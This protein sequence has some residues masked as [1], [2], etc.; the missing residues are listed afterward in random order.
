MY[1]GQSK[2]VKFSDTLYLVVNGTN[3]TRYSVYTVV[4]Q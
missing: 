3:T 2:T 1:M 4:I